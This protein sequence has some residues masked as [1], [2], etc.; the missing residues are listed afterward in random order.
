MVRLILPGRAVKVGQLTRSTFIFTV[1]PSIGFARRGVRH[2]GSTKGPSSRSVFAF[3]S[4]FEITKRCQRGFAALEINR[5]SAE[6]IRETGN[7]GSATPLPHPARASQCRTLMPMRLLVY[8]IPASRPVEPE[9]VIEAAA[10][11]SCANGL[12]LF[13]IHSLPEVRICSRS[14][15]VVCTTRIDQSRARVPCLLI[16]FPSRPS[17]CSWV[18]AP[19]IQ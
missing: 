16:F 11:G 4:A 10:G 12:L 3:G 13:P 8:H 2:A 5:A 6:T 15:P 14:H 17:S 9:C 1:Q 18:G 19:P 7:A